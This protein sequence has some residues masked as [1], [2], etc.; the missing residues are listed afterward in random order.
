MDAIGAKLVE[1]D[2]RFANKKEELIKQLWDSVEENAPDEYITFSIFQP[3]EAKSFETSEAVYNEITG[4]PKYNQVTRYYLTY[5]SETRITN[6]QYFWKVKY[7][8]WILMSLWKWTLI[9]WYDLTINNSFGLK[10]LIGIKPPKQFTCDNITGKIEC[11]RYDFSYFSFMRIFNDSITNDRTDFLANR[12]KSLFGGAFGNFLNFTKNYIIYGFFGNILLL[13]GYPI[14]SLLN[15]TF[16]TALAIVG[17]PLHVV[18]V[19]IGFLFMILV[20]DFLEKDYK[21]CACSPI[22]ANLLYLIFKGLLNLCLHILAVIGRLLSSAS[23][24]AYSHLKYILVGIYSWIMYR[25]I[26]IFG[27]VP[28]IRTDLAF[29]VSGPGVTAKVFNRIELEDALMFVLATLEKISLTF[30]EN[31]QKKIIKEPYELTAKIN[32]AVSPLNFSF[33]MPYQFNDQI[34]KLETKL[35]NQTNMRRR[36]YPTVQKIKF[37]LSDLVLLKAS[38]NEMLVNFIKDNKFTEIWEHYNLLENSWTRLTDKI[39]VETFNSEILE[40]LED[41]EVWLAN[42][43]EPENQEWREVRE[44]VA[45]QSS[46]LKKFG[47]RRYMKNSSFI[48]QAKSFSGSFEE[49]DY[50]EKWAHQ[51]RCHYN[52]KHKE[53]SEGFNDFIYENSITSYSSPFTMNTYSMTPE[54][55]KA[56]EEKDEN[57]KKEYIQRFKKIDLI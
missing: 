33:S 42:D 18:F 11:S 39:L 37:P 25:M 56:Y 3:Y 29:P 41:T 46:S 50:Y 54:Q 40:A 1:K 43:R 2:E 48:M 12:E 55:R 20:F 52:N 28:K 44:Q 38:T 5:T 16:F 6:N 51:E 17:I 21:R 22:I 57:L 4:E 53:K 27:K 24:F 14:V 7:G 23:I 13:L 45:M 31:K 8:F 49:D 26:R 10:G 35:I 19:I 15:I 47:D 30:F 9:T 32:A 36:I 34:N